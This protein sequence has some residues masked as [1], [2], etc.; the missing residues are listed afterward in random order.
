MN[1]VVRLAVPVRN[2]GDRRGRTV[3]QVYLEQ[4]S[5]SVV[6]PARRLVAFAAVELDAGAS[7]D[8]TIDVPV[9]RFAF[10]DR[11]YAR[12]VEPG[13]ITLAVGFASDDLSQRLDVHVTGETTAVDVP[14]PAI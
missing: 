1:E 3:V 14:P 4:A 13:D 12:V 5:A 9:G 8:V 10:I 2:R 6:R 7:S 11:R